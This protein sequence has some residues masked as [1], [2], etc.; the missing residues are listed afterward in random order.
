MYPLSRIQEITT[1]AKDRGLALHLDGARLWNAVVA[2]GTSAVEFA[3]PF[4]TV[5]VLSVQRAGGSRGFH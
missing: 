3:K 1:L 5:S 2:V 4:D